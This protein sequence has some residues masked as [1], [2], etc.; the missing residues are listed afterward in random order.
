MANGGSGH[1]DASGRCG[2]AEAKLAYFLPWADWVGAPWAYTNDPTAELDRGDT[3]LCV[4][5]HG[6]SPNHSLSHQIM[7]KSSFMKS[8]FITIHHERVDH[9]K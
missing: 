4:S 3:L 1:R 5:I 6:A 2:D 8:S 9:E 7:I